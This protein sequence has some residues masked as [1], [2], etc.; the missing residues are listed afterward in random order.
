VKGAALRGLEGIKPTK[1]RCRRHYGFDIKYSFR[2]GIDPPED[3]SYDAFDGLKYCIGM[4]EWQIIKVRT[5]EDLSLSLLD[6]NGM[7]GPIH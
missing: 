6:A 7:S 3:A 5:N 1:K 2:E 4:V